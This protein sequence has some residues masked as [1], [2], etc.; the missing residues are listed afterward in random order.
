M[1][2]SVDASRDAQ[3]FLRGGNLVVVH[4]AVA[5]MG[6]TGSEF[7]AGERGQD[8]AACAAVE[9]EDQVGSSHRVAG[10]V[11]IRIIREDLGESRLDDDAKLQVR[12][13]ALEEREG[14]SGEHAV[15]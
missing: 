8:H 4:E 12:T 5:M 3:D 6:E 13:M 11:D 2:R 1:F 7:R 15:A 14:G 10:F 9:I